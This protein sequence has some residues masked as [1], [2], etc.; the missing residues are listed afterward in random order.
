MGQDE[1]AERTLS[2]LVSWA[3]ARDD[4]RGIAV[5]GSR[6]RSD[7]P[8][9]P[10]SDLDLLV[11]ARHPGRYLARPEWLAAIETP[12]LTVKEP[13]P[14]GGQEILLVTFEG[15]TKV[16][17]SVVPSRA[18]ALA[19]RAVGILRR[20]PA[21]MSLL[22]GVA[23]ERLLALSDLLNR[24]LRVVLD[25]DGVARHLEAGG[26]P[27][28]APAPPSEDEFSDLVCRFLNE[29]VWI[30]LKLR[31][32]ELFVA[33]TLGES[34]LSALLLR[35]IEWHARAKEIPWS[36]AYEHG[37]LLE[38]WAPPEVVRRL[39]KVFP[40]YDAA[41][42]WAARLAALDLFRSLA[43]ETGARLGYPYPHQLEHEVMSWV[44]SLGDESERARP[45]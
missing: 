14:I 4:L 44:R 3:T 29:Q 31:R 34:R 32:G 13:T 36:P 7:H 22:P 20:Y 42:I 21:A 25:K 8:A 5:L 27:I 23:R 1:G 26:L 33:R 35:M 19:A 28:P 9:D 15:G 39:G 37:R 11:M 38:S 45:G 41:E 2:K 12:W 24:G 6:A 10:W 43:E 30:A 18:F 16:D 17:I 40:R